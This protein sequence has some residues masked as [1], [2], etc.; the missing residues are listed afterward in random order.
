MT[1]WWES[2]VL[3]V[4][5]GVTLGM[6]GVIW[7]CQV[8]HYP[9]FALVGAGEF[10]AYHREHC[11]RIAP[12]VGVMMPIELA[13][14]GWLAWSAEDD[15]RTLAYAGLALAVSIWLVTAGVQARQHG[16]LSMGKDDRVIR[17]LVAG[18]W[19]RTAVWTARG[20][21]A[22]AMLRGPGA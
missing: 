14:A 6:V 19:L 11:R 4:H 9:L 3:L 10:A 13:C 8:V 20:V 2:G 22:L 12:L 18:N 17:A 15:S 1:G 21:I 5:A 7:T 16:R